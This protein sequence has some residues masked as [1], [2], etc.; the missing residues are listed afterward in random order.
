MAQTVP[1]H[2]EPIASTGVLPLL[3]WVPRGKKIP[4]QTTFLASPDARSRRAMAQVLLLSAAFLVLVLISAAAV[5]L[6]NKAR[7]DSEWLVHTIEVENQTN[8]LLLEIRRA[9]SG[10]RGYLLTEGPEFL[11]DHKA[12]VAEIMPELDKLGELTHD[13]PAQVD[14]IKKLRA[15]IEA[16]LGQFTE[17]LAFVERGEKDKAT[18]LVREGAAG[19]VR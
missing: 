8:T 14:N 5:L 3:G 13:N 9:E 19:H 15:A 17:E 11:A 7:E 1:M 12:A 6:V 2:L 16:R 4:S 10:A 18:A